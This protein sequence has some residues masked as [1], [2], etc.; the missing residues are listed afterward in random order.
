M[1]ML[2]KS[3]KRMQRLDSLQ[4]AIANTT[5]LMCTDLWRRERLMKELVQIVLPMSVRTPRLNRSTQRIKVGSNRCASRRKWRMRLKNSAIRMLPQLLPSLFSSTSIVWTS[6]SSEEARPKYSWV[7]S[8]WSSRDRETWQSLTQTQRQRR[9]ASSKSSKK[10]CNSGSRY[11]R[12]LMKR[13]SCKDSW[14]RRT[15]I[16]FFPLKWLTEQKLLGKSKGNLISL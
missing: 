9:R 7:T 8:S 4:F 11:K 2:S 15:P 10:T 13:D 14:S 6:P 16:A 12:S 3:S 1:L 5:W